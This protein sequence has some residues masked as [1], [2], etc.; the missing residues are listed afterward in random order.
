MAGDKEIL[1][2]TC[3]RDCY[4][5]CGIVAIKRDGKITRV[6]GDPDH[7]VSR[8]ALCGKCAL[9]YNG[10][11]RDPAARL[12]Q[13]LKRIGAK[14]D[15]RFEPVSWD[16]AIADIAGR[17]KDISSAAGADKIVHAHYTGTCSLIAN[18][19]P[20]RFLGRLGAREVEPDTVCN[21][22]GHVAL[23]YVIGTSLVGFDPRTAKDSKCIMVWGANPSASAPHQHKHWLP[24]SP[25]TVIV[26]DPVRHPTAEQA[27][28]HLQPFPGSDAALAFAMLHVLVRD[29]L[30]D[31]GFLDN[32]TIGW[33]ELAPS[34]DSCT[35]A[36]GEAQTGVPA[37][38]IEE[39]ARIYGAGPS[40]LWLGQGL[41]R[42]PLGGNV[43]RACM[44]LPAATGRW[45]LLRALKTR[46]IFRP[47][48]AGTSIPLRRAPSRHACKKRSAAKTSSPSWSTSS[49]PTRRTMPITCCPPRPS[50]SSTIWS[51][52]IS[53]SRSQPRRSYKS[54]SANRCPTRKSSGVLPKR[55]AS[56]SGS[57]SRVMPR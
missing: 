29:R 28:M 38:Q 45:S 56:P 47:S 36:W 41:Q 22:A 4:D 40:L 25:G 14:G 42:Q 44:L 3:P 21:M 24:E 43:M 46:R 15:G 11:F 32:H 55:W 35:P 19:F 8:G 54:R 16:E 6:L 30:I 17:F 48:S 27:D 39:A 50:W 52:A 53:I 1:K 12:L 23:D 34:I 9:A 26:V 20:M 57:F 2:T 7:P 5:A 49:R 31:Q 37:A 51:R 10:V 13:P 33:D 18:N